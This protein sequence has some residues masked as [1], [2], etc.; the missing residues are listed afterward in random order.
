MNHSKGYLYVIKLH[1]IQKEKI[2]KQS[3]DQKQQDLFSLAGL[4]GLQ[5]RAKGGAPSV[6]IA[7][8]DTGVDANHSCL[9]EA[10]IDNL[11]TPSAL[12]SSHGTSVASVLWAQ[13]NEFMRGIAPKCRG[14]SISIYPEVEGVAKAASQLDIARAIEVALAHGAD[15]INI[16]AGQFSTSHSSD[17]LLAKVIKKCQKRGVL[18]VA[19]AGNDGCKCLHLPAA[20]PSILA[21]GAMD[22]Y[23]Q[24]AAFSNW[25]KAYQQNGLLFP[26]KDIPVAVLNNEYRLKSGTSYAAPIASGVVALL[27][28]ISRQYK[29]GY[30][31]Q[32]IFKL[33]LKTAIQCNP[34]TQNNCEKMLVGIVNIPTVLQ[35]MMGKASPPSLSA[36]EKASLEVSESNHII[37]SKQKTAIMLEKDHS[38]EAVEVTASELV[39]KPTLP[40][41]SPRSMEEGVLPS[42][43]S[44]T[45]CSCGGNKNKAPENVY[46]IGT[47]GYQFLSETREYVFRQQIQAYGDGN[48]NNPATIVAYLKAHP[49]QSE[50]ILWVVKLDETPIYAI[51]PQGAYPEKT[52]TALIDALEGFSTTNKEKKVE[53][54][55]IPGILDGAVTLMNGL[56]VPVL[57][58]KGHRI[59]GWTTPKLVQQLLEEWKADAEK[60]KKKLSTKQMEEQKSKLEIILTSFL[61]KVYYKL[62]NT[63]RSAQH[64]A[65]NAVVTNAWAA[66]SIFKDAMGQSMELDT[67]NVVKSAIGKPGTDCWDVQLTFFNPKDLQV[68]RLVYRFTV[69]V[70]Y[71]IPVTIGEIRKWSES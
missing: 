3:L 22:E 13:S 37:H 40:V 33:L 58:P 55:S 71:A 56:T 69:D 68:A 39:S 27:L 41:E 65:L 42:C 49:E 26:G 2:M 32:G 67:I 19:A 63:G 20:E 57:V 12:N 11:G 9:K 62:R 45:S 61:N 6:C 28:S 14:I 70:S 47:L 44:N 60:E 31:P 4:G 38:S 36:Q 16:S 53:R 50:E 34:K 23:Q 59:Y 54:I 25:G 48:V 46:T 15:I 29:L 21:V 64:R 43:G 35:I 52:Y 24:P 18:I 10:L 7:I 1:E 5:K 8:L 17:V 51:R 66:Y 30:S